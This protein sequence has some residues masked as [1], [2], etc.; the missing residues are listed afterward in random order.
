[1]T[2]SVIEI[3]PFLDDG[4]FREDS[5]L[6]SVDSLDWSQY[7]DRKVLVRGC[8]SAVV[9]PWAYMVITARL[10]GVAQSVRFGNEHDHVVVHRGKR[11]G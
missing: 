11:V 2:F 9:P 3:D 8:D 5:F 4:M 6:A 1:M 10:V 7:A